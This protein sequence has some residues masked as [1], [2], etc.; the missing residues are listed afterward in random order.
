MMLGGALVMQPSAAA[1]ATSGFRVTASV[2]VLC[3]AH[4][5][6]TITL[7]N[8]VLSSGKVT[9]AC[10]KR[11]GYTVVASYRS[12]ETG[13]HATLVYDGVEIRLPA[14]GSVILHV[15]HLATIVSVAYS[16]SDVHVNSP[17]ALELDAQPA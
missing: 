4:P 14:S 12:L 16:V 13:E 11:G 15:S 3:L 6:S 1:A 7:A 2:P 8:G 10:N 17:I 5:D 9:E